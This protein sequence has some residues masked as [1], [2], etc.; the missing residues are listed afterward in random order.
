MFT[1]PCGKGETTLAFARDSL[2]FVTV[3]KGMVKR[4]CVV[5]E[6]DFAETSTK[7][8]AQP[9]LSGHQIPA[10]VI[11]LACSGG[12]ERR[13]VTDDWP[14]AAAWS[15]ASAMYLLTRHGVLSRIVDDKVDGM[16]DVG[17]QANALA[18]TEQVCG[19][20]PLGG[21]LACSLITGI[22]QIIEA[23]AFRIQAVLALT[24]ALKT[25]EA[26]GVSFAVDAEAVWVLYADRSL[27]R[28]TS[29]D[30]GP[31]WIVSAPLPNLRDAQS[32]PHSCLPQMLTGTDRG[33]QVWTTTPDGLRM[34]SMLDLCGSSVAQ[35]TVVACSPWIAACGHRG[36]SIHLA[37]LPDLRLL[38]PTPE[39][40]AGDVLALSFGHWRPASGAPLL[41]MSASRDRSVMLFRIDLRSGAVGPEAAC[42][43]L[44]LN[45]REHSAAVPCAA[46]MCS[47]ASPIGTVA[48]LHLAVCTA[49][50][51]LVIREID[52]SIDMSGS[53]VASVKRTHKQTSR[54]AKWIA[55][56]A[57]P[58][59]AALFAACA[60]RRLM[61][62]DA[63]GRTV[64]QVKIAGTDTELVAPLRLSEDGR[65]LVVGIT[66]LG[67]GG[68]GTAG[69]P[70]P[71]PNMSAGTGVLLL[72][73]S[74]L[75]PLARL[76]GRVE[77]ILSG[78]TCVRGDKV[79]ACWPDGCMLMWGPF[80]VD[81]LSTLDRRHR[82]EQRACSPSKIA[83]VTA[84]RA[85]FTPQRKAPCAT[86]HQQGN[87]S[88]PH[89]GPPSPQRP[90]AKARGRGAE[91][92]RCPDGLLERLLATSPKPPRWAS[93]GVLNGTASDES[94][95][96]S[97]VSGRHSGVFIGKWA[98]GS[99]VGEQVMSA[100]DLHAAERDDASISASLSTSSANSV[101]IKAEDP[102]GGSSSSARFDRCSS[103]V[104]A[105]SDGPRAA[106][107]GRAACRDRSGLFSSA[108]SPE[109]CG[110][111][112]ASGVQ[113]ILPPKPCFPPPEGVHANPVHVR[114]AESS[115]S[116]PPV[117]AWSTKSTQ[118][119]AAGVG[120]APV[121]TPSV[122]SIATPCRT[123]P[124]ASSSRNVERALLLAK[125]LREKEAA[126][127]VEEL[128][129]LLLEGHHSEENGP[130]S[131]AGGAAVVSQLR[132]QVRRLCVDAARAIQ[133]GPE[134]AEIAGLL[135]RAGAL[136]Q[137]GRPGQLGPAGRSPM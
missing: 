123:S 108:T 74:A 18:W 10:S 57:H 5:Q 81:D 95:L 98:R 115:A 86:A 48:N 60:D 4:W 53:S 131:A 6:P 29:L 110:S 105:S 92:S 79:L 49:D 41:L 62:I 113:R 20:R 76:T 90:R 21:L 58:S 78:L 102:L 39:K 132:A 51:L 133:P 112:A 25:T 16:L 19:L 117:F 45:L 11:S 36:G 9:Q 73:A 61:Q 122:L 38:Q 106:R 72:D 47:A 27:A 23:R 97:H 30:D 3:S 65:L 12:Q 63:T 118:P 1:A 46:L 7:S 88:T 82:E 121:P 28:W 56:H 120:V 137:P 75:R 31:D 15:T 8:H 128:A 44:L 93:G 134:S 33:M 119:P 126:P 103:H 43:S 100:A 83:P 22:V 89:R 52:M 124:R 68:N 54:G 34:E 42:V 40:H 129:L 32:I 2:T 66:S 101:I 67:G 80:G 130:F 109:R 84:H 85:P 116:S 17:S 70:A 104:R 99:K 127:V 107:A 71:V 26:L 114:N 55:L 14:V 94:A 135:R 50:K 91:S 96:S 125:E 111:D 59:K 87:T 24:T 37:S 69:P 136:P 13:R 77:P 64:H 35:V